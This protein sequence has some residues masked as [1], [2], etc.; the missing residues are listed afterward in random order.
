MQQINGTKLAVV[1]VS[2]AKTE[3]RGFIIQTL[4]T[5]CLS[6]GNHGFHTADFY[7]KEEEEKKKKQILHSEAFTFRFAV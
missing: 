6:F 5:P 1:G 4:P 7:L 3:G 2:I